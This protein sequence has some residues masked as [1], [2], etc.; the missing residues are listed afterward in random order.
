M[1]AGRAAPFRRSRRRPGASLAAAV[2]ALLLAAVPAMAAGGGLV[3]SD[4]RYIQSNFG[5]AKSSFT[6]SNIGAD[7]AARLHE[8]INDP[9]FNNYPQSRQR[10]VG[11]LL[12]GAV[13]R[14]CQTWQIA[15]AGASCPQVS[16]KQIGR[17]HV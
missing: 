8:L 15:H 7:D 17:A 2:A 12:F 11:D 14:T 4:Y 10:S 5:F 13:M 9:T 3:D 16:D 1:S 6:L